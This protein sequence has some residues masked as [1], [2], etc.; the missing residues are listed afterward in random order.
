MNH[1]QQSAFD[2]VAGLK[3]GQF[4]A[5][6][7]A[8]SFVRQIER[9]DTAIGSFLRFDGQ[10]ALQQSRT[11][12]GSEKNRDGLA[13][14]PIA[15]KDV[16]CVRDQVTSC[17]SRML[18]S[19]L[20]PYDATVVEKLRQSKAVMLG[21]TNM[22][23]FAMGSSTE[24]SAFQPTRNP[25]NPSHVPGG[26]SGG[27]ATCV[28]ARM[29]PLSLGSDTGGSVRQ[30]AA[31][32]GVTGLKPTYGRISRYGLVAFASSLD[33]IGILAHDARDTALLL[34][35]CVGHD[36]RDS[37]SASVAGED[38]LAGLGNSIEGL[39]IGLPRE[40]FN[41]GLNPEISASLD[42]ARATFEQQGVQFVEISLPMRSYGVATYYLVASC[43]ASGNLARYDGAHF[44]LRKTLPA[45]NR[46]RSENELLRMYRQTRSQGFGPEVKRRIMLG[47]YALS[48][49][50]YDAYYLKAL[51]SRRLIQD[52]LK[53][54]FQQ[55]DLILGPTTPTPAYK[56][57]EKSAN[58]LD[59]YLGDIYTVIA[60]LAGIP[61]ISF[62]AGFSAEGLPIGLQLQGPAF[63]ESRLLQATHA[64]QS[65]TDWHQQDPQ[66]TPAGDPS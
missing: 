52:E 58:P 50:Y 35:H 63:S 29:A 41:E 25:W 59:M 62:P 23:E 31:F 37:T 18:E 33:Q 55:V 9:H 17:S 11:I 65:Q 21:K 56:T 34:N 27:A 12:D 15:I 7:V 4:S 10:Q 49:G 19:F 48:S 3:A 47:T 20:S 42:Q 60:N 46:D 40:Y 39:K 13:G 38:Y 6:E 30:P 2:L 66:M 26:S 5:E 1:I 54:A 32:C 53:Q 36:P 64:F 61:A 24:N 45:E 43:E 28:A 16:I 22:D 44:G 14:I 51:K 57:G 8:D